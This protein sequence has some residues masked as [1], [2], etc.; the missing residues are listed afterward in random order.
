LGGLSYLQ[1]LA[2]ALAHSLP[3]VNNLFPWHLGAASSGHSVR[4][5]SGVHESLRGSGVGAPYTAE[6]L[7]RLGAAPAMHAV[8]IWA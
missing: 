3:A 2:P 6:A 4:M 1:R 5:A 8:C 7:L